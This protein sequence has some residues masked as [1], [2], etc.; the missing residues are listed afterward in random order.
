DVPRD[1]DYQLWVRYLEIQS[2]RGPFALSVHQAGERRGERVFD[3]K[4]LSGAQGYGRFVWDAMPVTLT[5]GQATLTMEKRARDGTAAGKLSTVGHSRQVDGFAL[6]DDP[7]YRPK[8]ADLYPPLWVKA[9]LLA[10]HPAP[11]VIHLFGRNGG[12]GSSENGYYTGHRSLDRR[13]LS[14]SLVPRK[15]MMLAAG[16]SSA[17]GDI[18]RMMDYHGN[19]VIRFNAITGWNQTLVGASFELQFADAPDDAAVFKRVIRSGSGCGLLVTINQEKRIVRDELD[20]SREALAAARALPP[21]V[22]RRATRF[23]LATGLALSYDNSIRETLDNEL[24]VLGRLGFSGLGTLDGDF[25]ARGFR[26]P[27]VGHFILL[28]SYLGPDRCFSLPNTNRLHQA[29]GAFGE[30]L[31]ALGPETE[32]ASVDFMDEPSSTPLIHLTTCTNCIAGF[33]HYLRERQGLTP[34]TFGHVSWDTVAPVTNRAQAVLYHWTQRYRSQVFADFFKRGTEILQAKVPDVRTSVNYNMSLSYG[35]NMLRNG[36]DWF[37]TQ[38]EGLTH[39]WHEDWL[40]FG[41]TFQFCGYLVDFQRAAARKRR[42]QYGMYNIL[43]GRQPWD[44]MVKSAA[45]IGH[46][47]T[48]LHYFNY[49]P[50]YS[51]ASDANSHRHELYPALARINHAI[52]EVEDEIVDGTVPP[53]RIAMLYSHS[54]D[55]WTADA[56][57]LHGKERQ[58]FWLLL[59]HLGLPVEIVAEDEVAAGALAGYDILVLHGSHIARAAADTLVPWVQAG[60]KLY[61]GAGS[62]LADEYNAPLDLRARL[63]L[64]PGTFTV[65]ALP[66]QGSSFHRLKVLASVQTEAGPLAAVCGLHRLEPWPDA[67]VLGTF[68]DG[69]P[70][71]LAGPVGRGRVIASGFFPGIGYVRGGAEKRQ[72]RD[73]AIT[74][75]PPEFPAVYRAYFDKLM[76]SFGAVA[77]VA[78]SHP[79]VEVNR[80][81]SPHGLLLVLSNWSGRPLE[82]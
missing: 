82:S 37:L 1:G 76:T 71:L 45:E 23:S 42:Q 44:I 58:N 69:R 59:R 28:S 73:A 62:G 66:G 12:G 81:Q 54:T 60:G 2:V 24:E 27:R 7:D 30:Q 79:L 78:C 61:L 63:G 10:D 40:N 31:A 25:L 70:A 4:P 50:A 21:P 41:G 43:G 72:A 55:I 46:G 17:W 47:V 32:V 36:V 53:S 77:P 19:N 34:A 57:S 9:R 35:G 15:G 38:E 48:A 18:S 5:A 8:T 39:G 20:W 52:G 75:N 64:P 11:S 49:G 14:G 80:I 3:L 26:R 65:E 13:G 16:E 29:L 56:V 33:R 22:G 51:I 68:A 74:Y 6:S 67:E